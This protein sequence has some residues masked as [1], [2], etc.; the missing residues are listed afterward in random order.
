MEHMKYNNSLA[1]DRPV[2]PTIV[3][4]KGVLVKS[5]KMSAYVAQYISGCG[6]RTCFFT[7]S[8]FSYTIRLMAVVGLC[9]MQG[10]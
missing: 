2:T 3:T 7:V 10:L 5:V 1:S 4:L 6:Y 8:G 9:Q